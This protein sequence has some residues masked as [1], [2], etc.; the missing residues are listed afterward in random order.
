M[1]VFSE[2]WLH[3]YVLA[4]YGVMAWHTEEFLRSKKSLR[5]FHI[6]AWR[7]TGRAL[8][9]IGLVVVFDDEILEQYNR[10]AEVDYHVAEPWM[11]VAAGFF[12]TVL[13]SRIQKFVGKKEE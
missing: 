11:Y 9:W 1:D 12:I 4:L 6:E 13:R 8:V 5:E 3:E 2:I 10:W 7:E